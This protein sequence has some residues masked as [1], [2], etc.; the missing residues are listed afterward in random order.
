MKENIEVKEYIEK[1]IAPKIQ[2]D[3]GWIEYVG[4]QD[5]NLTVRLRGECSKCNIAPRCMDWVKEEIR[6]DLGKDIKVTM[7]RNR[8]F[9]WDL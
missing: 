8:P 1:N 5:G 9:F 6:R 3:G 4:F 7:L 2:G